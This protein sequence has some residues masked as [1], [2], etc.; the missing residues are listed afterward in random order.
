MEEN[1]DLVPAIPVRGRARAHARAARGRPPQ[2]NGRM[3]DQVDAPVPHE[4]GQGRRGPRPRANA[5]ERVLVKDISDWMNRFK[6]R[7]SNSAGLAIDKLTEVGISLKR[8]DGVVS[9]H[10]ISHVCRDECVRN[11]LA[12][13]GRGKNR[14]VVLDYFGS[15]RNEKFNPRTSALVLPGEFE[16]ERAPSKELFEVEF[17]RAPA[18][19]VAGDAAR[20]RERDGFPPYVDLI[21]IQDVYHCTPDD[22]NW[23]LDTYDDVP[24]WVVCRDFDGYAGAEVYETPYGCLIEGVW[25]VEDDL[26]HFTPHPGGQKY[27]PH[28]KLDWLKVRAQPG[29]SV[30]EMQKLLPFS[31]YRIRSE[32]ALI[33]ILSPRPPIGIVTKDIIGGLSNLN[34]IESFQGGMFWKKLD[35]MLFGT[36]YSEDVL[37]HVPTVNSCLSMVFKARNGLALDATTSMVESKFKQ[38]KILSVVSKE[39]PD[40]YRDLFYGTVHSVLYRNSTKRILT[41]HNIR[42]SHLHVEEWIA[43]LRARDPIDLGESVLKRF[44]YK[45]AGW[46]TILASSVFVVNKF[47]SLKRLRLAISLPKIHLTQLSLGFGAALSPLMEETSKLAYPAWGPCLGVLEAFLKKDKYDKCYSLLFHSLT[48]YLYFRFGRKMYLPLLCLHYLLNRVFQKKTV[49]RTAFDKFMSTYSSFQPCELKRGAYGVPRFKIPAVESQLS[50]DAELDVKKLEVTCYGTPVRLEILSKVYSKFSNGMYPVVITNGLLYVPANSV[51]NLL[52]CMVHRLLKPCPTSYY[53]KKELVDFDKKWLDLVLYCDPLFPAT[54]DLQDFN[55]HL[56]SLLKPMGSRAKRII[57]AEEFA[58]TEGC[59]NNYKKINVKANETIACKIVDGVP[60]IKPRAIADLHPINH[61]ET[62]PYSRFLVEKLKVT[63]TPGSIFALDDGFLVSIVFVSGYTQEKLSELGRILSTT[64][65]PTVVV[66]GDDTVLVLPSFENNR[67]GM[68]DE[69]MCDQCQSHASIGSAYRWMSKMGCPSAADM[70]LSQCSMPCVAFRED[71]HIKAWTR[72]MLATGLTATTLLNTVNIGLKNVACLRASVN[73]EK[74]VVEDVSKSFG[75]NTK[76]CVHESLSG[77]DFLKGWWVPSEQCHWLPLPSLL[78]KLGKFMNDPVLLYTRR[79]K[80]KKIRPS[81]EDACAF[82]AY[83]L[84]RSLTAIPLN[85]PILGWF[86]DM[87]RRLGKPPGVNCVSKLVEDFDYKTQLTATDRVV[88]TDE[89]VVLLEDMIINRYQIDQ[90]DLLEVKLL[91]A[92]NKLLPVLLV[93]PVFD[94]L[95]SVDYGQVLQA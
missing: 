66:S 6:H 62:A 95:A 93:H 76:W 71:F 49:N 22:V 25:C 37:V 42:G 20:R 68:G 77:V 85:Y 30:A 3:P 80:G 2:A 74:W 24:I 40:F 12:H 35:N 9:N 65:I 69:T 13:E 60:T 46:L 86:I 72:P 41:A 33:P 7:I 82:A 84:Y 26:V 89:E 64:S 58:I 34:I 5:A 51:N 57:N 18:V 56:P 47:L 4:G 32:R 87:L 78:V 27:A 44:L 63:W 43:K 48:G 73:A 16:G 19:A 83:D 8:V 92:G 67:F 36:N 15:E 91:F 45:S 79:V 70:Y 38:D 14:L 23:L 52:V 94:R 10:P 29:F 90:T 54:P 50:Y 75:F 88:L 11:V 17:V 81:F 39:Y 61:A 21:L 1:A 28:P 53:S 59:F 31:I 55:D